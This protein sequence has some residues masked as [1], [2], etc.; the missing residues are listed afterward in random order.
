MVSTKILWIFDFSVPGKVRTISSVPTAS[1]LDQKKK[2]FD[3]S[4]DEFFISPP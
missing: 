3:V 1:K 2:Q 4:S